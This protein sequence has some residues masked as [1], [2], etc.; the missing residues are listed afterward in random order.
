M[1]VDRLHQVALD[2]RYPLLKIRQEKR[3][4]QCIDQIDKK[5]ANQRHDDESQVR[6][7]VALGDRRH[8]RHGGGR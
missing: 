2:L 6:S 1:E 3:D 4:Q 5:G 7:A 8:V